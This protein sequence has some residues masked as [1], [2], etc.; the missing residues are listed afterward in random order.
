MTL[1]PADSREPLESF[2]YAVAGIGPL[3]KSSEL[4]ER[5]KRTIA[6]RIRRARAEA[7][8]SQQ[9]LASRV[10]VQRSAVAQW[11]SSRATWPS[12]EHLA[13]IAIETGVQFEWLCTGRGFKRSE[14]KLQTTVIMDDF[15]Q[16]DIESKMLELLRHLSHR[17]Q[18]R[19]CALLEILAT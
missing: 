17:D 1:H 13:S 4:K 5:R 14:E 3:A 19:A 2:G 12:T 16:N 10:G 6:T 8:L 9:Q 18:H 7:K 11:E 15:A